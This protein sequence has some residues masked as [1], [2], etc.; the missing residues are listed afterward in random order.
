MQAREGDL[1]KAENQV[2][3]DVK[4]LVHP[5]NKFIAFPRY[6]PSAEGTRGNKRSLYD[7]IYSFSER[8]KFL[9]RNM[10]DL[11][12]HDPVFDETLCEVPIGR[13]EE[14][15]EPVEKL[16][17]LRQ[18]GKIDVLERKALQLAEY[19]KTKANLPWSAI[20]VSGSVLAGL[21]T[22]KSDIDP[23]V[24]GANNC[25]RAYSTLK[26]ILKDSSSKFKRYT[27]DEL[28]V[29]FEF[30]SKDT[31]MQFED[32]VALESRKVFQGM[33]DGTDYFIRFV[34]EWSE[35]KE[36][37]GS[38]YYKNC[39]YSK[40]TATV[41]DDS[42]ALFTPCKYVIENVRNVSG[43]RLEPI[44]EIVSFRGRFCE[45][46]KKDE[47]I[48]AQGKIER[49]TDKKGEIHYRIILGNTPSDYMVLSHV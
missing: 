47:I 44:T 34:K 39:G 2:I 49:V 6:I 48:E 9:E 11:I 18:S 40:V 15:F 22:S 21:Y 3:F 17:L 46:A 24:Y 10:P 37:Y 28:Q 45:Q 43:P 29:L 14:H 32:F 5:P 25:R 19:L 42:E 41:I 35:V 20:G 7:K 8:F 31:A 13:V 12:V 38:I 16:K 1:I 23:V 4:G 26:D 33:F 36:Q 30:R 27:L